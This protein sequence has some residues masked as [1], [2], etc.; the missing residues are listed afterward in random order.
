MWPHSVVM[1]AIV[2]PI[3]LRIPIVVFAIAAIISLTDR[4]TND[5]DTTF[6]A[7]D[8]ALLEGLVTEYLK[9]RESELYLLG[10][11][12]DARTLKYRSFAVQK[13]N[14]FQS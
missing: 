6:T 13:W 3:Y 8:D 11:Q 2:L 10:L 5:C 1:G 7:Y 4:D 14:P 9:G 12:E